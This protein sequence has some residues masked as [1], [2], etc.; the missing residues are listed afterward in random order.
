L[1]LGATSASAI[2]VTSLD[3]ESAQAAGEIQSLLTNE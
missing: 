1:G 2:R 3:D